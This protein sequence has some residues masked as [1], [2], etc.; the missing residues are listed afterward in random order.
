MELDLTSISF[1][2]TVL[3]DT[4]AIAAD[5]LQLDGQL[6]IDPFIVGEDTVQDLL[7]GLTGTISLETEASSLGFLAA[8]LEH[9][10]WLRLG[11]SGHL[12]ADLE[13][14]NGWMAPGSRI[15]LEG[16]MVGADHFGLQ[17]TGEGRLVGVVPEDSAHTELSVR[18]P[19]FSLARQLDQSLLL[20]GEDLEVVVTNDSTA[21]DRPA[22]GIAL[23][24]EP[25]PARAPEP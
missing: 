24:V 15:T 12:T 2:E 19:H 11:G 21:I 9:L 22:P 3:L 25:P 14:T 4:G 13:T 5:A 18:L 17:A 8:Y 6:R 7:A 16:P 1:N 10:P 20:E 23:T